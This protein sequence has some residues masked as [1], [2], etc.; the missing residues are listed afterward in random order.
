MSGTTSS[1]MRRVAL[2]RMSGDVFEAKASEDSTIGEFKKL[3]SK[4]DR[5]K[6]PESLIVLWRE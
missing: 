4:Q 5:T 1:S 3:L 6:P 2:T